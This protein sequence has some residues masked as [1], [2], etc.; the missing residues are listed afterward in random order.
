MS[1]PEARGPLSRRVAA[2]ADLLFVVDVDTDPDEDYHGNV[3]AG[4]VLNTHPGSIMTS[5]CGS[6][7]RRILRTRSCSR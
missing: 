7:S 6:A 2:L 1:A 3:V 5:F 4:F